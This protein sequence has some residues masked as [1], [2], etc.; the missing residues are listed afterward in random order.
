[1]DRGLFKGTGLA[2]QMKESG[3]GGGAFFRGLDRDP[4][5]S[6]H[7][8]QLRIITHPV[9]PNY[10]GFTL[11]FRPRKHHITFGDNFLRLLL[12][13]D[14]FSA[15]LPAQLAHCLNIRHRQQQ[16]T[17]QQRQGQAQFNA[18]SLSG[19]DCNHIVLYILR[20]APGFCKRDKNKCW[21]QKHGNKNKMQKNLKKVK[22]LRPLPPRINSQN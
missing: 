5:P 13:A 18:A 10:Q 21:R 20:V 4:P 16:P 14:R 15:E 22:S 12:M 17:K 9:G 6:L 11:N 8:P 2:F 1:M 3:G 19:F 7:H